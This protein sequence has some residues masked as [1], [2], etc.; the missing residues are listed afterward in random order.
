MC[1]L[2]LYTLYN[3]KQ[4]IVLCVQHRTFHVHYQEE[5]SVRG[6]D[7]YRF[8]LVESDFR[9]DPNYLTGNNTPIGLIYLGILQNPQV[10]VY[11]SKP[12]FLDC[13]KSLL[14]AVDGISPPDRSKHDIVGDIEPV[15]MYPCNVPGLTLLIDHRLCIKRSSAASVTYQCQP[16]IKIF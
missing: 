3:S 6:I 7:A 9:P 14:E 12:H 15:S 5:V 10:P 8:R 13:D 2:V 16:N 1:V 4:V 11:G